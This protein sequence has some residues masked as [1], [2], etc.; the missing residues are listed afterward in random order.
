M[1]VKLHRCNVRW[2]KGPHPCWRVEKALL[3]AG[4]DYEVV[5]GSG[6]PWRRAQRRELIEKTGQSLYPA[7]EFEDGTFYRAE[8]K[9]MAARIRAGELGSSAPAREP[10]PTG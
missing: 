8:S 3:D 6:L 7:I 5:G 10:P 9:V 4:I 2:I 1:A